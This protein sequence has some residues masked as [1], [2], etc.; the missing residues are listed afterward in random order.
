MR[1]IFE[2]NVSGEVINNRMFEGEMNCSIP[3][4]SSLR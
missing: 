3:Q 1:T 2:D 4:G